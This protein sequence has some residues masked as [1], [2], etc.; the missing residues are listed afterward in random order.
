MHMPQQEAERLA[1][2][3]FSPDRRIT[4]GALREKMS[5]TEQNNGGGMSIDETRCLVRSLIKQGAVKM[6]RNEGEGGPISF[7]LTPTGAGMREF[8]LRQP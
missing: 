1:L 6:E 4:L 8:Q 2:E 3:C 5:Q 7:K